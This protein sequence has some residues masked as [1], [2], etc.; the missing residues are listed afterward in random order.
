MPRSLRH[1]GPF[2][3]GLTLGTVAAP[4]RDP[5]SVVVI[6]E[7]TDVA[8]V[9]II[10]RKGRRTDL[11][12]RLEAIAD[13]TAP[14]RPL[15]V[16][17]GNGIALCATGPLEHWALS[18]ARDEATLLA[19]LGDAVE[20]AAYLYGQSHGRAVLRLAGAKAPDVLA[21]GCPLDLH[22][23]AF[24]TPGAGHTAT[25][26]M[27]VL[28]VKQDDVPTFDLVVAR[29]YAQSFLHWLRESAQEFGYRIEPA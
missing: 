21:K 17:R 12:R 23:R 19:T 26:R 24:P 10:A 7:V 2:G 20:D 4:G 5:G 1:Q 18:E 16:V 9:Q 3:A 6:R 22:P 8:L 14:G 28:V 29:S 13:A 27:P 25:E 15:S 11:R